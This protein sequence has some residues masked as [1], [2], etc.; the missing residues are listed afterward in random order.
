MVVETSRCPRS[1]LR[2]R[3]GQ[4]LDGSDV[5]A[6]FQQVCREGVAECVARHAFVNCGLACRAS[7]RALDDRLVDVVPALAALA[8]TPPS[9]RGKNPLP[10]GIGGRGR[11]L[12][13]QCV[14]QPDASPSSWALDRRIPG[15]RR[16]LRE[17][18][19]EEVKAVPAQS[20]AMRS[21]PYFGDFRDLPASFRIAHEGQS[22]T[23]R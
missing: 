5:M 2:L 21:F 17:A 13:R 9:L 8:V 19:R 7:H 6:A 16:G 10:A 18:H 22:R 4:A 15:S 3:S 1:S 14:R 11:I 12:S 20:R 23:K